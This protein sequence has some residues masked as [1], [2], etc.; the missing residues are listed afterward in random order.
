MR[1]CLESY[2][3]KAFLLLCFICSHLK[4]TFLGN[5]SVKALKVR[6]DGDIITDVDRTEHCPLITLSVPVGT[7]RGK[8]RSRRRPFTSMP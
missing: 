6:C 3:Y 8:Q 7:Q 5:F 2:E 1:F 4:H